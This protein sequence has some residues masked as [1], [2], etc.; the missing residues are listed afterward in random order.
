[1]LG[2][3]VLIYQMGPLPS[4]FTVGLVVLGTIWYRNYAASRVH[5][6]GAIFHVFERL[7]RRRFDGLETE[8]RGIMKE[9]GAREEDPFDEVVAM[10]EVIEAAPGATFED[11]VLCAAKALNEQLPV[12]VADLV[13][14]F[15]EGT[16]GGSTPV[17]GGVA[18]P[19]LRLP[20]IDRPRLAIVRSVEGIQLDVPDALGEK[21]GAKRIWAIFFLVSPEGDPTQHLRMLAHL[22]GSAESKDFMGRWLLA[23]SGQELREILLRDERYLSVEITAG[24]PW[25]QAP[26][27]SLELP[28]GSLIVMI[29]RGH[30]LVVPRGDTVLAVGDRLTII[31]DAPGIEALRTVFGLGST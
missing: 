4:L 8:L 20:D 25:E 7:G 16:Q 14:G 19:H 28:G 9:K 5:R 21:T 15:E 11:M 1:M 6:Y 30:E 29:R 18:L 3:G 10:A 22:A 27:R 17:A 26:I 13:T 24:H 2:S 23:R 12:S 31:G